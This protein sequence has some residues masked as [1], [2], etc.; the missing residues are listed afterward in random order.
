[1]MCFCT[2]GTC[3]SGISSPRSPRA[4]ITPLRH[5]QDAVEVVDRGGPLDFCDDRNRTARLRASAAAHARRRRPSARSSARRD[6]RRARGRSADRLRPSRSWL[7]AAA[8]RRALDALVLSERSAVDDSGD[9]LVRAAL[10]T[11][12]SMRPSSSSRRSPGLADSISGWYGVKMQ[13]AAGQARRRR[14]CARSDPVRARSAAPPSSG[15]VRIFGPLRSCITATAGRSPSAA[16]PN[17][18]IGRGVRFVRSVREV[19]PEHVHAGGSSSR[20][21]LGRCWARRWRRS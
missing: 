11:R 3:S 4:T 9:D 1:M 2:R 20:S 19:Q 21:T 17:R 15:P 12:S 16:G 5:V 13:P 7:T 18:V 10:V 6:R 8:P 14:R